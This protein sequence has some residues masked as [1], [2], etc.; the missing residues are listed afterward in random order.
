MINTTVEAYIQEMSTES[1]T[2]MVE[3][4]SNCIYP[5]N[6]HFPCESCGYCE[7]YKISEY[8]ANITGD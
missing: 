8:E 2:S 6:K 5:E 3:M 1:T 4:F 7:K